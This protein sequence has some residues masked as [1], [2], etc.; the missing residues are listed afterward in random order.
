MGLLNWASDQYYIKKHMDQ[1]RAEHLK[2]AL[3]AA[4]TFGATW[5]T[6]APT[7]PAAGN[8]H[9]EYDIHGEY[10][11]NRWNPY[12]RTHLLGPGAVD[13]WQVWWHHGPL[14]TVPQQTT[15]SWEAAR[16]AGH[17]AEMARAAKTVNDAAIAE[18]RRRYPYS[19]KA[20]VNA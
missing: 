17:N 1:M 5:W 14:T 19:A 12:Q 18:L 11:F 15:A 2:W 3:E 13:S 7:I 9:V 6:V 16:M 4:K 10:T 20:L 8:P